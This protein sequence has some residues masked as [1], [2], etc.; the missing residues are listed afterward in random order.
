MI[1]YGSGSNL[2]ER[3][4]TRRRVIIDKI[5]NERVATEGEVLEIGLWVNGGGT[6]A[7]S[8]SW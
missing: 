2:L 8:V 4:R 7:R 1:Q 3:E 5:G 6:E